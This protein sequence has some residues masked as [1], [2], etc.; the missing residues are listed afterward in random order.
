MAAIAD[1]LLMRSSGLRQLV[2]IEEEAT[3]KKRTI[4]ET[5]AAKLRPLE[6]RQRQ[7][8]ESIREFAEARRITH[9]EDFEPDGKG[10]LM[11]RLPHCTI[12]WHRQT[13]LRFMRPLPEVIARLK[14]LGPKNA[15][16][17]AP[18]EREDVWLWRILTIVSTAERMGRG[19]CGADDPLPSILV[20][21]QI[22]DRCAKSK[23]PTESDARAM[24]AVG[25]RS[26]A[27]LRAWLSA[28]AGARAERAAAS[29]EFDD[30]IVFEEAILFEDRIAFEE[31][32]GVYY[33]SERLAELSALIYTVWRVACQHLPKV[34]G[35]CSRICDPNLAAQ[36]PEAGA[37]EWRRVEAAA[38]AAGAAADREQGAEARTGP[39]DAVQKSG[40]QQP[41][42]RANG[43]RRCLWRS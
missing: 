14:T 8:M 39:A 41:P 6:E 26:A 34:A 24:D 38:E 15:V 29:P 11:K 43:Q 18:V 12:R 4:R 22:F 5:L 30:R 25:R 1:F 2:R 21:M 3:A 35:E 23:T 32:G 19:R 27:E 16:E 17:Y 13:E 31:N 37:R 10:G 36:D 7:L 20:R 9:P 40:G 28:S 42:V 33:A